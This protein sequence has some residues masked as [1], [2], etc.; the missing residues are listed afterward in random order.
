MAQKTYKNPISDLKHNTTV[1][2]I[3]KNIKP[4]P[5]RRQVLKIHRDGDPPERET[6]GQEAVKTGGSTAPLWF[7]R[8]S[9]DNYVTR[10]EHIMNDGL[11]NQWEFKD[12]AIEKS[13]DQQYVFIKKG[14]KNI[15]Y[16]KVNANGKGL[17]IQE[18]TKE[19][20]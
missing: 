5:I 10:K 2:T 9:S 19:R 14:N 15:G 13:S 4:I 12:V 3:H 7:N 18:F 1:Y 6:Q 17:H 20:T 8:L 11:R 16:I